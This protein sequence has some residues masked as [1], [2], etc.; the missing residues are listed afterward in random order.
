[1]KAVSTRLAMGSAAIGVSNMGN[2]EDLSGEPSV[3]RQKRICRYP[4]R[5]ENAA[6]VAVISLGR[7]SWS[8]PVHVT[9]IV[10]WLPA[11]QIKN[12]ILNRYIGHLHLEDSNDISIKLHLRRLCLPPVGMTLRWILL[13]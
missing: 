11:L 6:I 7:R 3:V 4:I 5:G 13:G 2:V 9:I 1:M 12:Q 8:W 10:R